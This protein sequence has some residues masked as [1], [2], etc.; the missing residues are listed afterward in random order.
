MGV[1]MNGFGIGGC[2]EKLGD[3]G[4]T[5]FVRLF[6]IGQILPVSLRFPGERIHQ[7]LFR[8]RHGALL[9]VKVWFRFQ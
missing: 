4:Q 6:G 5:L 1:S 8:S 7:I 9:F 2:S 3:L